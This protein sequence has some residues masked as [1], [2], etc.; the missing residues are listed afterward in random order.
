MPPHSKTTKWHIRPAKTQ[1]SLGIRPVWSESSLSAWIKLGS[2]AQ[3]DLSLRWAHSH[4]V[5]FVT[6]RLIYN[7]SHHGFSVSHFSKFQIFKPGL[8]RESVLLEPFQQ[9][10]VQPLPRIRVLRCMYVGVHQTRHNKLTKIIMIIVNISSVVKT[11]H[12]LWAL[13]VRWRALFNVLSSE[14]SMASHI[15]CV[16]EQ[17]LQTTMALVKLRRFAFVINMVMS[18]KVCINVKRQR[19]KVVIRP[20]FSWISLRTSFCNISCF[21]TYYYNDLLVKYYIANE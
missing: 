9:A 21:A 3:A 10:H 2:P 13:K 4:F 5:G 15:H 7:G 8:S 18:I 17:Q 20:V 6:R 19:N 12:L 16:C 14:A 1:I 11:T